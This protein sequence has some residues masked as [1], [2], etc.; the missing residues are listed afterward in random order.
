MPPSRFL[1]DETDFRGMAVGGGFMRGWECGR[2]GGA[3]EG[4]MQHKME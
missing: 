4:R 2:R 1:S 3:P